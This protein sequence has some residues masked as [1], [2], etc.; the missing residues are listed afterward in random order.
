VKDNEMKAKGSNAT[1]AAKELVKYLEEREID[2]KKVIF[3]I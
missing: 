1:F 2:F 3:S